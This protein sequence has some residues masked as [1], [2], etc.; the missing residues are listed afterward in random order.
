MRKMTAAMIAIIMLRRDCSFMASRYCGLQFMQKSGISCFSPLARGSKQN[1]LPQPPIYV[2]PQLVI[3][4]LH[5]WIS[6]PSRRACLLQ[7]SIIQVKY[8]GV[9][10]Q[11]PVNFFSVVP[12]SAGF[13]SSSSITSLLLLFVCSLLSWDKGPF[14][15]ACSLLYEAKVDL[16]SSSTIFLVGDALRS[17]TFI[18]VSCF[19]GLKSIGCSV[20]R[21]TISTWEASTKEVCSET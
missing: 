17:S 4:K 5:L 12:S 15:K 9:L 19:M 8:C 3:S 11:N 21:L 16:I 20:T 14:F 2:L 18:G 10:H 13:G 6:V 1:G 7:P